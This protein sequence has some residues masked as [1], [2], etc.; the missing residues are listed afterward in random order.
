M[1]QLRLLCSSLCRIV[2]QMPHSPTGSSNVALQ[3]L[4]FAKE[5]ENNT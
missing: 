2:I 3:Q 1:R 4:H 5:A